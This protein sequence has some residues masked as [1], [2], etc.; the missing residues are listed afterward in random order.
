MRSV[1][2]ILEDSCQGLGVKVNER[3]AVA[4][5][6]K[7]AENVPFRSLKGFGQK[8]YKFLEKSYN[9]W[10]TPLRVLR[11]GGG[12]CVMVL[13]FFMV[14]ELVYAWQTFLF[15]SAK[16]RHPFP[17]QHRLG[18]PSRRLSPDN[19]RYRQINIQSSARL[20]RFYERSESEALDL[21]RSYPQGLENTS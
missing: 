21:G 19:V 10:R 6:T 17:P 16:V 4:C 3:L 20:C 8:L 5:A 11:V 12:R 1:G 7:I 15:A 14:E 13:W 2:Q 9:F 18:V